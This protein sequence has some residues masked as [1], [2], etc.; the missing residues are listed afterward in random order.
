[1]NDRERSRQSADD[2]RSGKNQHM[3]NA[4]TA[5]KTPID[6]DWKHFDAM[7]EA[8]RHAAALSDSDAQPITRCATRQNFPTALIDLDPQGSAYGWNESRLD[9]R[10]IDATTADAGQIPA[11]LKFLQSQIPQPTLS[12][13]GCRR[14]NWDS[15]LS[16]R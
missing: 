8:Q 4:D 1:M 11:F 5:K 15:A 9:E 14:D 12:T 6:H 3:K 7:T 16:G 13:W 10:K 2:G